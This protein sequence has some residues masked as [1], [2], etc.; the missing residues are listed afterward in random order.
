MYFHEFYITVNQHYLIHFTGALLELP[1]QVQTE[2]SHTREQERRND[3]KVRNPQDVPVRQGGLRKK[4]T[5]KKKT[6]LR[7]KK[8]LRREKK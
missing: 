5:S 2:I 7:E 3:E 8:K 1:I 4:I 6:L